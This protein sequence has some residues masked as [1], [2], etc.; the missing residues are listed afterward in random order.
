MRYTQANKDRINLRVAV[1]ADRDVI[2]NWRNDE[3]TRR[4]FRDTA[5]IKYE[6]HTEWFSE[7]LASDDQD[8]LIG[9]VGGVSTGV[10]RYDYYQDRA[11]VSIYM[12][13]GRAG[14]GLGSETLRQ[15]TFWVSEHRP[16]TRWLVASIYPEN[17]AS[18]RAFEKAGYI[19]GARTA[20]F[21][22]YE[23]DLRDMGRR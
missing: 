14:S 9:E 3:N 12:A 8:L 2:F 19:A 21:L 4:Y 11:A 16:D 23:R 17:S 5:P 22:V 15:G 1:S 10:L 13:P 20:E 7:V 6:T 18:V